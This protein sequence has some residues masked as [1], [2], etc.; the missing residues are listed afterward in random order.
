MTDVARHPLV[1]SPNQPAR[2]YRGGAGLARFRGVAQGSAY[3]PEDFVAST[4]ELFTGGGV[5]LSL[6]ADGQ[7]LRSA[8]EADPEA[9]LGP[10]HVARFGANV[11]V[12]VKLLDTGERLLVHFHPGG[13]FARSHLGCAHGKNEAWLITD[14]VRD[15]ADDS[16]GA[17]FLGFTTA[18]DADTVAAWVASQ[19]RSAMLGA[20]NRV[21][22]HAGDTVFVPTGVPHAIGAGVTMVEA[23]EPLDL[24]ILLEW[25]GFAIDG[26]SEGHLGV[27]FPT[28]LT[29]LDR[30]AWSTERVHA[31]LDTRADA[32]AQP[33]VTTLLPEAADPYFRAERLDLDG[34]ASFPAEFAVLVV[35]GGDATLDSEHGDPVKVTRGSTVLVPYAAGATTVTGR[36]SALRCRPASPAD[37]TVDWTSATHGRIGA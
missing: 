24:S 7:T 15:G 28:A 25:E 13:D 37:T 29:A 31:L 11:G 33:G 30:S 34:S 36:L 17:A 26:P 20:L 5:G 2:F 1:F 6:L 4:T 22:L 23:Q 12:L 9:F 32:V 14:V 3:T 10:D 16:S 35:V 21:E 8:V 27:G 18:V 19:D